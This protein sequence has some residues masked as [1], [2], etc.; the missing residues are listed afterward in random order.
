MRMDFITQKQDLVHLIHLILSNKKKKRKIQEI[1]TVRPRNFGTK[2]L[3]RCSGIV[4][5]S[6]VWENL[7]LNFHL[8]GSRSRQEKKYFNSK[9]QIKK[10]R[11]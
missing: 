2:S 9:I 8:L 10:R 11:G 4:Q 1:A 5:S 7:E 3:K 6:I